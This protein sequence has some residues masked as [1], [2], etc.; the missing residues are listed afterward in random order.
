[1]VSKSSGKG[2]DRH[3]TV[4]K[5]AER[6]RVA[7]GAD[8]EEEDLPALRIGTKGIHELHKYIAAYPPDEIERM[9]SC[10]TGSSLLY[11]LKTK[12][13]ECSSNSDDNNTKKQQSDVDILQMLESFH[14]TPSTPIQEE[15]KHLH[16]RPVDPK[17]R[18]QWHKKSQQARYRD[19]KYAAMKRQRQRLPSFKYATQICEA[20]Q[21]NSV[22]IISGDTG[23]G[24][25]KK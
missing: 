2:D 1:M 15:Q 9:E 16:S 14:M 21:S 11:S 25:S 3:I 12:S 20:I 7:M 6:K 23:C 17:Q 18:R 10:E 22:V 5:V 4:R 13:R 19:P 24:K 8:G